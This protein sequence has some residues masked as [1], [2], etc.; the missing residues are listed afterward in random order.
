MHQLNDLTTIRTLG[1]LISQSAA[2]NIVWARQD[3]G[4]FYAKQDDVIVR[5][6]PEEPTVTLHAD[7]LGFQIESGD[8]NRLLLDELHKVSA[9]PVEVAEK[10]EAQ[11]RRKDAWDKIRRTL[12]PEPD[13]QPGIEA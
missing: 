1:H 3:A 13:P 4:S 12:K 6:N 9:P 7:G 11:K 5:Y 10:A 8:G 2:G